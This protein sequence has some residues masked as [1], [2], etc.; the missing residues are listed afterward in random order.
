MLA[1]MA[2]RL[3]RTFGYRSPSCVHFELSRGIVLSLS[4]AGHRT[5]MERFLSLI[6]NE[7]LA[8]IFVFFFASIHRFANDFIHNNVRKRHH[9][10]TYE[11]KHDCRKKTVHVKR[12]KQRE[13]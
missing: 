5:K 10:K 6:Y 3:D 13:T 1:K 12:L 8:P 7:L 4:L 2:I 11:K 9:K